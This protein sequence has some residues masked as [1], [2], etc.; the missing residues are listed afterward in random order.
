MPRL[1]ILAL[2]LFVVAFISVSVSLSAETIVL[3]NVT[4][5]DGTGRPPL[6]AA[7]V[8]VEGD[9][10]K[11]VGPARDVAVPPGARVLERSG[12]TV[13]PGLA[14]LHVHLQGGWDGER[15]D[16]L[17]FARY[18]DALLYSGVTTVLDT[19]NSMPFVTQVKQE[20]A[21]GRLRGPRIYCT[22]PMIDSPEPLW[23]PLA[24]TMGSLSQAP[25]IVKRLKA[26]E[27]DLVKAYTGLSEPY[28]RALARA[29]QAE[30]LRVI[31]D[32]WERNGSPSLVRS[33]IYG[34]AHAPHADELI[35]EAAAEMAER[36]VAV[37]T[38]VTVRESFS[39]RRL[40]DMAL[41]LEPLVKDVIPPHFLDEIREAAKRGDFAFDKPNVD[42]R[43][44]DFERTRKN[45]LTLWRAGVLVAA[46][47]DAP[48][49]GVFQGESMH[50]ELE[51]LVEAGLT[52]LEAIRA[53]TGNAA[54]FL[55]GDAADW[56]TVEPGRRADL[57]V[58]SGR[59]H[60]RIGDTRRI[61]DVVQGGRLLDRAALKVSPRDPAYRSS[62]S[63]F[64]P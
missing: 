42:L 53:A 61:V 17:G 6:E 56:G 46:G 33:G 37:I 21:A 41:L 24:E 36:K 49:P 57:V 32:A 51:L 34:F 12:H 64:Q 20:V 4:V 44:R 48:Y 19:G 50:R 30:G 2:R 58:V 28:V 29:A 16:Y 14:D 43:T 39:H 63:V 18:L 25:T 55:D 31:V 45:V 3:R 52:P 9:R 35:P 8:V 62:G 23:P 22:G 11:S 15:C 47:T 26:N 59:P 27:V 5:I 38:T 10:I 13:L 54:R 1:A 60:E 7:T 40:Q